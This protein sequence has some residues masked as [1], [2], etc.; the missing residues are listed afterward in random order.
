MGRYWKGFGIIG[1]I[2][3]CAILSACDENTVPDHP[4]TVSSDVEQSMPEEKESVWDGYAQE[5]ADILK[6]YSQWFDEQGKLVYPCKLT[7][8]EVYQD[9]DKCKKANDLPKGIIDSLDTRQL[10]AAAEEY[11][12][13]ICVTTLYFGEKDGLYHTLSKGLQELKQDTLI[14]EELEKHED[15]IST[16]YQYYKDASL[17]KDLMEKYDPDLDLY[18][19]SNM[20]VL[21]KRYKILLAEYVLCTEE[22]FEKLSEEERN[23][24]VASAKRIQLSLKEALGKLE[25]YQFPGLLLDAYHFS[26]LARSAKPMKLS[27]WQDLLIEQDVDIYAYPP[28]KILEKSGLINTQN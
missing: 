6:K 11:P 14:Y 1:G 26:A 7:E 17:E 16:C 13:F 10:C 15:L 3:L 22:A 4:E 19:G 5:H 25:G 12:G 20:E 21:Q 28:E 18:D 27:P 9:D 24:V 2:C 23:T 8:Q